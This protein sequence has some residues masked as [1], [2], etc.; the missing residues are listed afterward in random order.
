MKKQKLYTFTAAIKRGKEPVKQLPNCAIVDEYLTNHDGRPIWNSV[1]I[2]AAGLE[3]TGF[4]GYKTIADAIAGGMEQHLLKF[5]KQ[6]DYWIW[7]VEAA[8]RKKIEA[9]KIVY[10]YAKTDQFDDEGEI[11]LKQLTYPKAV[12][13]IIDQ[14]THKYKFYTEVTNINQLTTDLKQIGWSIN[15][16]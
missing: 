12:Q 11:R 7:N 2:V 4:T 9:G 5:G 8:E 1:S 13:E 15:L 16:K 10:C 6:D 3:K 14:H